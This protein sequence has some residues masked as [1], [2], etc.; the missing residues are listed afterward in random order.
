MDK[1]DP[2]II[3]LELIDAAA[4]Q[5]ELIKKRMKVA[6]E[7]QMSYD[8]LKRRPLEFMVGELVFFKISQIKGVLKFDKLGQLSAGYVGPFK[9]LKRVGKVAY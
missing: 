9:V 3:G 2:V 8:D 5:V 4:Q 1:K 7:R 6:Q